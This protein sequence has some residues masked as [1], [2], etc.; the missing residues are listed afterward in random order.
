MIDAPLAAIPSAWLHGLAGGCLIGAA[1]LLALAATGKVPG[2]S[3]VFG[4]VLRPKAGDT[5]WRLVFLIGLIGGAGLMMLGNDHA[6]QYRIPGGRSIAIYALAGLVVGFGTRLG[7]G[8]TSG[9]GICGTGS[10]ARD[11][12]LATAVFMATGILTVLL[13]NH[14]VGGAS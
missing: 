10:G 2:I 12:M 3:G 1:S 11:S 7:G 4:R 14:F 13:W 6:A 9:H 8:C 5:G